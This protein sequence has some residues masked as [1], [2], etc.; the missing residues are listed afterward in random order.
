ML[1]SPSGQPTWSIDFD[2]GSYQHI[3]LLCS[4][5]GSQQSAEGL[6]QQLDVPSCRLVT[7]ETRDVRADT[8]KVSKG[9]GQNIVS[10]IFSFGMTEN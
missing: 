6:D 8:L 1:Q 5:Q 10:S 9:T 7:G 4:A 2:L 3:N